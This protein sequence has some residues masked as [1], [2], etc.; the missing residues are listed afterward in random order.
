MKTHLLLLAGL[1]APLF[2]PAAVTTIDPTDTHA[3]GANIGWINGRGDV[4]NG[5]V[6]GEF[7]CSGYF[8]SANCGWVHL[9]SG[10]PADG[11]R[12]QNNS[13]TDYGVNTQDYLSL[14][15]TVEAKLRGYAYGANVGWIAF[16]ATGDPRV[17]LGNGQLKGHAYSANVGWIVLSGAGVTVRTIN[18]A[19][20][21]DSD[22]DGIPDAW[23]RFHAGNLTLMNALTDRDGD[24]LSD[25][26]EYAADTD[27]FDPT[28]RLRIT[29]FVPPRQLV[30]AGPFITDLTWTSK[31]TR[32][33]DIRLNP[34]LLSGWTTP[35]FNILPAAGATTTW[36]LTDSAGIKRFYQ[37][38]AKLPLSP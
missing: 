36:N 28:D 5:A 29:A 6:V 1:L 2:A 17:D 33:Y 8:Y 34:D 20:G 11:I 27:P 30:I 22:E 10:A 14:G 9:G 18:I 13:A 26:T 19:E 35:V 38:R 4:T 3:Y 37:I 15:G 16:E 24:G 23:E 21:T 12:Y 31:P 32:W 25:K 7:I